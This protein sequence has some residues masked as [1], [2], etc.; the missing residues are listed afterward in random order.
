MVY[1]VDF[2]SGRVR[3]A[4]ELHACYPPLL[5]HIKNSYASE[6]VVTDGERVY[7]YFGAIGLVAALDMNGMVIWTKNVGAFN[8]STELGP[9][10]SPLLYKDR[11]YVLNDN[12]KES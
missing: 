3:G 11:V 5:R 9:A 4:R 6:T 8:T 7:A 10:S 1:D 12:T 2:S